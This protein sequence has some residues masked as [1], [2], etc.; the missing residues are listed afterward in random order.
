VCVKTCFECCDLQTLSEGVYI[1]TPVWIPLWLSGS[2]RT[3]GCPRPDETSP[4]SEDAY[5]SSPGHEPILLM[6]GQVSV[7]PTSEFLLADKMVPAVRGM[8][9]LLQCCY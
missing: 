5:T 8:L 1:Q 3:Q 7:K 4:L 9:D 2:L 6:K